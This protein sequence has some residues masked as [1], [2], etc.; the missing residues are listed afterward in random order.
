MAAV[1]LTCKCKNA[2]QDKLYGSGKR[3]HNSGPKAGPNK[4]EG[5]RCT[6]CGSSKGKDK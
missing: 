5:Y 4:T 6:V 2:F 3:V 1:I